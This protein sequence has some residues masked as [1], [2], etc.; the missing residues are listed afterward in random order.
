MG[1]KIIMDETLGNVSQPTKGSC[2]IY[3]PVPGIDCDNFQLPAEGLTSE[4]RQ[5][6]LDQ[7]RDY[8]STQ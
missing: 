8:L 6:A 1:L 4:Q 7:L 2:S 3:P 5:I